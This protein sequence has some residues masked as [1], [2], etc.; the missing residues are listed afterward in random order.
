SDGLAAVS[1]FIEK[2]P[3]RNTGA[4]SGV[5]RMGAVH[6]F[7]TTIGDYQVTVVGEVP[8]KTVDLIGMSVTP[9]E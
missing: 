3:E 8:A 6:A 1:V 7:G 9:V 4:V 5:N 2:N